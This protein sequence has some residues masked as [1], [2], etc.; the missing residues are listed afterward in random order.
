MFGQEKKSEQTEG[1]KTEMPLALS[2]Y[3]S[4]LFGIK[5]SVAQCIDAGFH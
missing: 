1:K 3:N 4:A 5:K 2:T